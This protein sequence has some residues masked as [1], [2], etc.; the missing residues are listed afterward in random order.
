VVIPL[1]LV[2]ALLVGGSIAAWRFWPDAT[3]AAPNPTIGDTAS[4]AAPSPAE[5]TSEVPT[6]T[7][8]PTTK[9]TPSAK[10]ASGAAVRA[11]KDCRERVRAADEVLGEAEVGIAHWADHVDAERRESKGDISAEKKANIFKDTRLKGPADQK[12]YAAAIRRYERLDA[13]CG[14]AK[15]A[16]EKVAASLAKCQERL[17]AQKAVLKAADPAMK[18]W[19]QHLADMQRSREV[20]VKDAQGIWLKA[21]EAAPRHLD[22]Y[23]RA[24]KRFDAPDC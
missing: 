21:Y 1:A 14:P 2:L 6:E 24:V 7:P 12:R 11:L 8:S 15:G 3:T 4:A 16:D 18:D 13:T 19:K 22:P 20:H 5:S 17:K 9:A 23:E 10:P